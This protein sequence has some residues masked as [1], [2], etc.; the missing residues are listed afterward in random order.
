MIGLQ[1]G[2]VDGFEPGPFGA[3]VCLASEKKQASQRPCSRKGGP[4]PG[5][6]AHQWRSA[7]RLDW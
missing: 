6:Q 1:Q 5:R 3:L 2:F 4:M 7:M